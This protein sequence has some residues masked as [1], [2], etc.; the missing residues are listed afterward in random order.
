MSAIKFQ[1]GQPKKLTLAFD[2]PKTGTNSYGNWYMYG[3]KNGDLSSDEDCFFATDTLH[4]MIQ[5]LGA[6]EGDE[7][8]IEKCQDGDITFFKVNGLTMNDMN[9]G[10][11]FEK[12]A[13]SKPKSSLPDV[14]EEDIARAIE[15]SGYVNRLK[16]KIK[17]LELEVVSL[18][19]NQLTDDD[20]PF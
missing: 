11:A 17:E 7:I 16:T 20:I 19:K 1:I 5:T 8:D 18:K 14:A 4:A 13:E 2:T 9:S 3:F 10:G 12:I 6:K 15:N